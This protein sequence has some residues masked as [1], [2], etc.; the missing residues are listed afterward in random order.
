L[1]NA[2]AR[3]HWLMQQTASAIRDTGVA[4]KSFEKKASS[5]LWLHPMRHTALELG[6]PFE[7]YTRQVR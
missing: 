6:N 7:G 2:I 1:F 5:A 3:K 4:A